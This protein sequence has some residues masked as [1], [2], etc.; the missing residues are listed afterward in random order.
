LANVMAKTDKFQANKDQKWSKKK[1]PKINL[2]L[3]LVGLVAILG[4][5]LM[6]LPPDVF[7]S[8]STK[9]ARKTTRT[10]P[11]F[12]KEGV[13]SFISEKSKKSIRTIDIEIADNDYER[14]LGLMYRKKMD[15][16]KGMLFIQ[17]YM[18]PQ[19]FWMK[20]TYISLDII[21]VDDD[22]K[23]V[24]IAKNT[25]PFSYESIPSDSDAK[26]VVEVIAGFCRKYK[27]KVGDRIS[28][29]RE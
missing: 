13:L 7:Q 10:E 21:Y 25:E 29:D 12:K 2:V 19:S 26:Y 3:V 20:N 22:M 11:Q 17:E 23:I 18:E 4:V 27:V 16:S 6:V 14:A 9:K 28:F 1:K 5:L 8:A 24:S 15:D